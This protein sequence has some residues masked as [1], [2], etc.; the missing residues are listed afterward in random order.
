MADAY[1]QEMDTE[2][3]SAE[4]EFLTGGSAPGGSSPMFNS[5]GGS[6]PEGRR[7]LFDANSSFLATEVGGS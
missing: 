2:D 6:S 1:K 4:I 7:T 5:P 3:M